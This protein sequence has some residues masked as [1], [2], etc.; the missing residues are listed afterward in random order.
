M[1]PVRLPA[2][3]AGVTAAP[4]SDAPVQAGASLPCVGLLVTRLAAHVM[5]EH[6]FATAR[7]STPGRTA[8]DQSSQGASASV[9]AASSTTRPI[10][11]MV[12]GV[13]HQSVSSLV[14]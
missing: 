6:A 14:W 8:G 2:V 11:S 4:A 12:L 13:I 1:A 5:A 9:T 3:L 10:A 7:R